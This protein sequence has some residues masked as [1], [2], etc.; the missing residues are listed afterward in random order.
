MIGLL[1]CA[2]KP[3]SWAQAVKAVLSGFL[4]RFRVR[5]GQIERFFETAYLRG[6]DSKHGCNRWIIGRVSFENANLQ[7]F[8]QLAEVSQ[9]QL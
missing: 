9:F 2:S 5:M 8:F 3:P 1:A 7:N 6:T 4:V